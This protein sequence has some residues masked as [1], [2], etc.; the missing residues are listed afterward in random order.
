[1]SSY[2]W[3]IVLRNCREVMIHT[4]SCTFQNIVRDALKD[5]LIV[6]EARMNVVRIECVY[7]PHKPALVNGTLYPKVLFKQKVNGKEF[8]WCNTCDRRYELNSG[9][10]NHS[11]CPSDDC[12]SNNEL[13]GLPD[14]S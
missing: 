5:K 12:P 14:P 8:I 1:M 9:L 6:P 7:S 11:L 2:L 10:D 13:I 4:K 3:N